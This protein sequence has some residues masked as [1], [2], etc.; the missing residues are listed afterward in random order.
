MNVK[1]GTE[2]H[3]VNSVVNV[4]TY[5]NADFIGTHRFKPQ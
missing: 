4:S 2:S 3:V 5:V 1:E